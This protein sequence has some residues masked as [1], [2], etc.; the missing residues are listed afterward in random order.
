[1][2]GSWGGSSVLGCVGE[3][4]RAETE[5]SEFDYCLFTWSM[6]RRATFLGRC[7]VLIIVN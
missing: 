2:V 6:S 1:M 5:R 4:A 7:R 3:E